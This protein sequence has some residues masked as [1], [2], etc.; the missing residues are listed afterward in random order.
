[1]NIVTN[2]KVVYDNDYDYS[3]A[4]GCSG[5]DGV[6]KPENSKETQ[7]FQDWLDVRYPTWNNGGKLNKGAGY[8]RYPFGTQTAKAWK[9]YGAEF[10]KARKGFSESMSKTT[11]NVAL[12]ASV[13]ETSPV[14]E[15]KKGML[16][17]KA[18]GT[19]VKTSDWLNAHP[20]FKGKLM[21]VGGNV[22]GK[23]FGGIFG[24]S[25]PIGSESIPEYTSSEQ[26]IPQDDKKSTMSTPVK[27]T[28]GALAAGLLITLIVVAT[29]EKK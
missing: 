13:S 16:W 26:I 11:S 4:C 25:Q 7:S 23:L 10:H 2:R 8:G 27:I 5:F 21:E 3:N 22:L 17:D 6:S 28:L 19:W 29:K 18:K 1:M 12:P 9:N 14:G 24:G 15:K 20:E